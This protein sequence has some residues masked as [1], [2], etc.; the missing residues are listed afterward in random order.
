MCIMAVRSQLC[1]A[2]YRVPESGRN[3]R[4]CR[5]F[6]C[7]TKSQEHILSLKVTVLRKK[8]LSDSEGLLL[9]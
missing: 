3:V 4:L 2:G 5:S 9:P 1:P 7:F 6:A 8:L